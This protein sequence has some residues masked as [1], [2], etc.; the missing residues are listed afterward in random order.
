MVDLHGSTAIDPRGFT[1]ARRMRGGGS[2]QT[3]LWKYKYL[4]D[5]PLQD[6]EGMRFGTELN[7]K[8]TNTYR[9]RTNSRSGKIEIAGDRDDDVM[10]SCR[11]GI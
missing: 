6:L 11:T 5:P 10:G 3:Q 9:G 4:E 2:T 8:R 1:A 7:R